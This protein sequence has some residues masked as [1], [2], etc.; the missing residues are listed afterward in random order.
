MKKPLGK[1]WIPWFVD[2][3]VNNRDD[4]TFFLK[5]HRIGT[6]PTYGEINKTKIYFDDNTYPNSNF[7]SNKGLFLPLYVTL[8]NE[9]IHF[10]CGVI[11]GE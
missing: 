10:I 4:L 7:V 8:K 3:Y 1:E 6:R 11:R 5:K 9:D 2:I